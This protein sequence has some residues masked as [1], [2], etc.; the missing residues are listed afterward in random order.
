MDAWCSLM[1]IKVRQVIREDLNRVHQIESSSFDESYGFL[2][3]QKLF[4]IGAGFLVAEIEGYV[5][6]YI[7]FWI[8]EEGVGHIISIAVDQ[9]YRNLKIAS[10][11]LIRALSI[12]KSFNLE[13]I[14]LEVKQQNKIAIDFYKKF[15]FKID[16]I[17][18]NYYN[19]K[20]NA[21]VM[22]YS[23]NNYD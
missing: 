9:E 10:S 19:D 20:S 23:L 14:T 17:V 16:R 13:I 11:L 5:V 4:D 8:K 2:M 18:P 6:G 22:Y 3:F 12:L 7:L 21:I 15:D 1:D